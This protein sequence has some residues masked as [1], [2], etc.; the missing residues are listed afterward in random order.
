M[1]PSRSDCPSER[2]AWWPW[3]LSSCSSAGGKRCGEVSLTAI[4]SWFGCFCRR[5]ISLPRSLGRTV[6]SSF[7]ISM[8]EALVA[9]HSFVN[10][11]HTC[12]Y[13]SWDAVGSF[14]SSRRQTDRL[15]LMLNVRS[16][17]LYEAGIRLLQRRLL[18]QGNWQMFGKLF[19]N[20]D[21][22][23][24]MIFFFLISKCSKQHLQ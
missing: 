20:W 19:S 7:P 15:A 22:L 11:G 3:E 18:M 4:T 24:V 23:Q 13:D 9:A 10:P 12:M 1:P 17:L 2:Q 6:A 14:G 16:N 8:C 5:R 21:Q